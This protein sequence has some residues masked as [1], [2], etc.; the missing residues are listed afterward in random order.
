[1]F[2]QTTSQIIKKAAEDTEKTNAKIEKIREQ[3][4]KVFDPVGWIC[5]K[6]FSGEKVIT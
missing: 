3:T 2:F 4:N 1:L 5:G 6:L